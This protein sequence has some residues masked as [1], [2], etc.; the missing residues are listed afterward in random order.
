M[1]TTGNGSAAG[2]GRG[3]GTDQR[4]QVGVLP[5]LQRLAH[6]ILLYVVGSQ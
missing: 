2:S 4:V 6:A 3:D 1:S 5:A